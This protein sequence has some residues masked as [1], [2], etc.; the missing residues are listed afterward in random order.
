MGLSRITPD[1]WIEESGT[2]SR[3][4]PTGWAQES[5]AAGGETITCSL[6]TATA[7]G[8]AASILAATVIVC[9]I[10]TAD[11]SGYQATVTSGT[12]VTIS[13]S[14]GSASASG[15]TATI[16]ESATITTDVFKN[17]TGT[18]L[19]STSIPKVVAIKLSDLTLVASWTN[20]TTNGSGVLE[21]GNTSLVAATDYLLVTS[22]ADGSAVGVKKYTAA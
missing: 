4:T 18:V 2:L 3:V 8:F 6:G 14:L 21:V 5:Q 22:N 17:N 10:G 20:Q 11:A 9:S 19:A 12:N 13:C 7:S 15:Y 16:V 1:G